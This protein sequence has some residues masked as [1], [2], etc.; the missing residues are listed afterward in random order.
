MSIFFRFQDAYFPSAHLFSRV[1]ITFLILGIPI[2]LYAGFYHWSRTPLGSTAAIMEARLQAERE[3]E[4]IKTETGSRQS[5]EEIRKGLEPGP[6]FP[7][8][9][10]IY[11]LTALAALFWTAWR[12]GRQD[13]FPP[14]LHKCVEALE[15]WSVGAFFTPPSPLSPSPR[16]PLSPSPRPP[17]PIP[18]SPSPPSPLLS[19]PPWVG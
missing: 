1:S 17:L 12:R 5:L 16:P 4:R 7:W 15:R 19:S 2:L 6:L 10:A 9:I 11:V 3:A 18:P 8:I 14:H 13:Y